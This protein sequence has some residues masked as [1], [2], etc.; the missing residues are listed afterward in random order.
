M[1][2]N[3]ATRAAVNGRTTPIETTQQTL[4]S[5]IRVGK[6]PSAIPKAET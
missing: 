3:T 6:P 5:R 1:N 4:T 2:P